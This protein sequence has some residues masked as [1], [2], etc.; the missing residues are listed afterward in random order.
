MSELESHKVETIVWG[1]HVCVAV[2]E[3]AVGQILPWVAGNI[4]DWYIVAAVENNDTPINNDAPYLM[5]ILWLQVVRIGSK[6]HS[7]QFFFNHKRPHY[8]V[9]DGTV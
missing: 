3:I 7:S 6:L 9:F 2:W 5:K 4:H 1:Y 8:T